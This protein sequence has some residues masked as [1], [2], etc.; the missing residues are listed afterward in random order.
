MAE[1]NESRA[2][3]S[4]ANLRETE[5]LEAILSRDPNEVLRWKNE[6][7]L[8]LVAAALVDIRRPAKKADIGEKLSPAVI[9]PDEWDRWWSRIQP[10]LKESRHF[11]QD[12]RYAIRL[13]AKPSEIEP[14]SRSEP[15]AASPKTRDDKPRA[16]PS[17][18]SALRLVDWI[19]WAQSDEGGSAPR[20]VPPDGLAAYLRK[21][22]AILVPT[23]A[24]R[25]SR[26]IDEKILAVTPSSRPSP[27]AWIDL[28][29]ISLDRCADLPAD[30]RAPMA[31]T[32][33][34]CARL[35]DELGT[36]ACRNIIASLAK[37]ATL[38]AENM[39][40]AILI[41][42]NRA[43]RETASLLQNLNNSLGEPARKDMWR[44][45]IK[46]YSGQISDWLNNCW[47]N[48]PAAEEK[49]EVALNLII[50]SKD[51]ALIGNL[52]SLLSGE[53]D[54]A[55]SERRQHLFNPILFGWFMRRELMPGCR[56]VLRELAEQVGKNGAS[57]TVSLMRDF[58]EFIAV[59]SKDRLQRQ[60]DDYENK[61][62]VERGR[63][64]DTEAELENTTTR[65]TFLQREN[66]TKRTVATL[67]IT[68]DAI[69]VL[70][71]ALQGL[72]TSDIPKSREVGNLESKIVL[73]LSTLDTKP[74]GEIGE[75]TPYN[76][77]IHETDHP[78]EIE[79]PVKVMA[80]GLIYSRGDDTS[81]I[82]VPMNVQRET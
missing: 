16:A 60:G 4:R 34:F 48:I 78:P 63:L 58:E 74:F 22:P 77:E 61:L 5:G 39:A 49:A 47:R 11:S 76:P 1:A 13:R 45:L 73:A 15:V 38:N 36:S 33:V 41:S 46:S 37:C 24:S 51:A 14:A 7:P 57:A 30:R 68:R 64:R 66:R 9:S 82:V 10:T 54:F 3:S 6:N 8:R 44:C 40:N 69:I 20:G 23:S 67:E 18:S 2:S 56:R 19:D 31:E 52:D 21:Q 50:A 25:L 35:T 27:E 29:S 72:A 17:R 80:P 55:D 26:A 28:L 62:A 43:S 59:A 53:W 70:G 32:V 42:A 81:A 12:A 75:V 79:T 71:D 65:L